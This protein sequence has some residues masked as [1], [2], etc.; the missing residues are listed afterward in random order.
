VTGNKTHCH[1]NIKTKFKVQKL[2]TGCF[3]VRDPKVFSER[4]PPTPCGG[5][6]RPG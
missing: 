2:P 1:P 3:Y 6:L 4:I 5:L